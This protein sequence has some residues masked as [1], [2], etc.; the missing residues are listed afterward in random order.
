MAKK[1]IRGRAGGI[2]TFKKHGREHQ[3][4]KAKFMWA[5]QRGEYK[6]GEFEKFK[7]N[8]LKKANGSNRIKAKV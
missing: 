5:C 6:P 7:K 4:L 3:A 1:T 2:A 8:L